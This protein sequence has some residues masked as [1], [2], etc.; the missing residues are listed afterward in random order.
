LLGAVLGCQPQ[1]AR[2]G[3]DR[4]RA[5]ARLQAR[6]KALEVRLDALEAGMEQNT[7]LLEALEARLAPADPD[8]PEEAR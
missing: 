7:Q 1:P 2:S 3:E 6:V 4:A 8:A 5:S